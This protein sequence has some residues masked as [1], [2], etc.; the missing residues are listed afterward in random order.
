MKLF[1]FTVTHEQLQVS[2]G[3]YSISLVVRGKVTKTPILRI[4][5]L[6]FQVLHKEEMWEPFYL[7]RSLKNQTDYLKVVLRYKYNKRNVTKTFAV[8][9][10]I[11]AC[12]SELGNNEWLTNRGIGLE[13][14]EKLKKHLNV[15]NIIVT[16]N[17]V[18][19][20][21]L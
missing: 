10:S 16:N 2:K 9:E 5:S 4:N 19:R 1:E 7:N 21:L 3:L 8:E 18:Q 17:T 12:S 14:E 11:I 20:K 13:L 6:S 15:P